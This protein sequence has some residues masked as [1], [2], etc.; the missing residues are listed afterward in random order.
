MLGIAGFSCDFETGCA[1]LTSGG[2]PVA[3][4]VPAFRRRGAVPGRAAYVPHVRH[5]LVRVQV[6]ADRSLDHAAA[7]LRAGD[8]PQRDDKVQGEIWKPSKRLVN[9]NL[10]RLFEFKLLFASSI[11]KPQGH[12][13]ISSYYICL[14][15]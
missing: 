10:V 15:H 4:P 8:V 6:A 3:Y 5:V 9:Y 12:E 14:C 1:L 2:W 7:P 13:S 11:I